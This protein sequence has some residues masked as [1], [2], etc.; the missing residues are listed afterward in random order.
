MAWA[1]DYVTPVELQSYLK[2]EYLDAALLA[3]WVTTASRAV[4]DYCGRQFGQVDVPQAR[5]YPGQDLG[6]AGWRFEVDDLEDLTGLQVAD[7][8]ANPVT[9]Y[10]F[11][12]MNAV[13]KGR[14]Y[15][16]LTARVSGE[17]TVTGRWGWSQVP[18]AAKTATL[19]QAARLAQRRDSPFGISGSP[20]EQ[21]ELRL[22]AALDPD[23]R[24]SLKP[25]VRRRCVIA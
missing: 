2:D 7:A 17:L 25:L 18:A 4:D 24:T 10:T 20:Q 22:L 14:P 6:A 11:G 23:L 3:A 9:G 19:L 1:P 12:P 8:D 15:E 21:G 16:W 13:A 5:V